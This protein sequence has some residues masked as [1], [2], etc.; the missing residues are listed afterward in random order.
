MAMRAMLVTAAVTVILCTGITAGQA[1]E[2]SWCAAI[3]VGCGVEAMNCSFQS[4]DACRQE[5]IAGNK[6]SCFPNSRASDNNYSPVRARA[7]GR[8]G[9][10]RISN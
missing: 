2:G 7:S 9:Q 1:T 4:L 6:G 5:I 10:I 3:H 8:A